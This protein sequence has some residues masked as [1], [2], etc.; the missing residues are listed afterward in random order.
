MEIAIRLEFVDG[1]VLE[2][3]TVIT[4]ASPSKSADYVAAES[5]ADRCDRTNGD[6]VIVFINGSYRVIER[7]WI[8]HQHN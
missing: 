2:P 1:L 5:C 4:A 6:P 3:G 8:K 7:K